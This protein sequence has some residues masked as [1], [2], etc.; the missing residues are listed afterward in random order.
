MTNDEQ[1]PQRIPVDEEFERAARAAG[2]DPD[3]VFMQP[4]AEA[5]GYNVS[6]LYDGALEDSAVAFVS[7]LEAADVAREIVEAEQDSALQVLVTHTYVLPD[8]IEASGYG[9][10]GR[11][12]WDP[13]TETVDER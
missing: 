6:I 5:A 10:Y 11:F 13:E 9:P 3:D 1:Y 4:E 12:E 8:T 2:L 7:Y